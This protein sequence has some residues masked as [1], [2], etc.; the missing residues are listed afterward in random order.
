HR[1]AVEAAAQLVVHAAARHARQREP[2]HVERAR[3]LAA[4]PEPEQELPVHRLGK[5]R[6]SPAAALA[7]VELLRRALERREE[8]LVGQDARR[9]PEALALSDLLDELAA[10][11]LHLAA[12]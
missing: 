4:L 3:V 11:L 12:P 9:A 2:H 10:G 8:D 5:L 7:L 1:V 6:R